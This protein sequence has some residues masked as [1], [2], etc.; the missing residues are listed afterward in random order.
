MYNGL[1]TRF[2]HFIH[3]LL[4]VKIP[5]IVAHGSLRNT[6]EYPTMDVKTIY[7]SLLWFS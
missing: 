5:G 2:R 7:S 4:Q 6:P 3:H 1:T